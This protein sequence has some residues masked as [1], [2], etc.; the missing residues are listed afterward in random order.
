MNLQSPYP[1]LVKNP[2]EETD[3]YNATPH[4]CLRGMKLEHREGH[5]IQT[6]AEWGNGRSRLM[7]H[8][9]PTGGEGAQGWGS[10]L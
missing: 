7:E 5:I 4:Y 1:Q 8:H 9:G 10:D 6:S 3:D 2:V